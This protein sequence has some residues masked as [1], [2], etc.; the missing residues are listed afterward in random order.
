M[1]Q[2]LRKSY[3]LLSPK[4]R[5]LAR[6]LVYLPNELF[7]RRDK[8]IPPKGRIFIGSGDFKKQGIH[9]VK[10]LKKYIGLEP[11]DSVLDIGCGIGRSAVPLLEYLEPT[12]TYEGFD[13]ME[14]NINWCSKKISPDFPNFKFTYV[15]LK[16]DLYNSLEQKADDFVFP[17]ENNSFEK[18]FLFSV[19]THMQKGGVAQ[20]LSEI[21]RTL[22]TR[23]MCLAT[24]FVYSNENEVAI[25]DPE[26][27]FSFAFEKED[28]RIMDEKTHAANTAFHFDRLSKMVK[29][30][31]LEVLKLIDGYWKNMALKGSE[32]SFQ[33]ILILR[34]V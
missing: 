4:L 10:L 2:F 34:K 1:S 26:H 32:N 13:V 25:S 17:Y 11:R 18:A 9:Q 21:A 3:Y 8:Y 6:R 28:Y 29:D 19:F 24:F 12:S 31:G 27:E 15:P 14:E 7:V 33:D 5:L 16:N 20:Y 30:S 23:G 22:K